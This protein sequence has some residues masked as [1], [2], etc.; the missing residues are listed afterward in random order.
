MQIHDNPNVNN[1]KMLQVVPDVQ[2]AARSICHWM[3][4]NECDEWPSLHV[5]WKVKYLALSED[6][7]KIHTDCTYISTVYVIL[8]MYSKYFKVPKVQDLPRLPLEFVQ[9]VAQLLSRDFTVRL[10]ESVGNVPTNLNVSSIVEYQL[11][12]SGATGTYT[13]LALTSKRWKKLSIM[14]GRNHVAPG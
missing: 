2:V 12:L 9:E 8:S 5:S 11:L 3:I 4:L 13:R 7:Q 1:D 14:P 10:R 6:D